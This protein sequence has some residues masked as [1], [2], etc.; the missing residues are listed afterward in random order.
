MVAVLDTTLT[1]DL[2]RQGMVRDLV[3]EI[4]NLRKEAEFDVSDRIILYLSIVGEML[5]AVKENEQ[6]V[7]DEVLAGNIEYE[8][9]NGEISRD[10]VI[11]EE[12]LTVGIERISGP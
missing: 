1:K 11:G 4:N 5:E 3:H 8:F 7:A 10:L 12:K 9:E 6:Y 2:I